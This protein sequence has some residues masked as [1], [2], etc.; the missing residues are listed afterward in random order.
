M[1]TRDRKMLYTYLDE[2]DKVCA[3]LWAKVERFE[4]DK[5]DKLIVGA[6][7]DLSFLTTDM[8]DTV[9]RL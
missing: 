5:R 8:R 4:P 6:V 9:D 7:D 1:D 3:R 2:V